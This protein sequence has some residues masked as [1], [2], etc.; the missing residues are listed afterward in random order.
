[1]NELQTIAKENPTVPEVTEKQ[2]IEYL[3]AMGMTKTLPEKD[4]KMFIQIAQ[5]FGLNPFKR[6]I[7][8]IPYKTKDGTKYSILTGYE[9]YLKRAARLGTLDGWKCEAFGTVEDGSL[10]AKVT[11][12]R[13]DWSK[14]FEH[15]A[16][17]VEAVNK[18]GYGKPTSIWAKMPIFMTK[19][20]AI[21]QSF[22]LCFSDEFGGLPYTTDEIDKDGIEDV[23]PSAPMQEAPHINTTQQN[24]IFPEDKAEYDRLKKE[25]ANYS[26]FFTGDNKKAL[27][28]IFARNDIGRMQAALSWAKEQE[29]IINAQVDA[30]AQEAE[31]TEIY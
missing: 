5:A 21:A 3:D 9:V 7:Y 28:A 6:E 27:E 26:D 2:I 16:H 10:Y 4:K 25:L 31:A 8:C 19:K 15:T 20:V 13:K 30:E 18:N 12:Y 1:M 14:P 23:T 22:R 11:I 29:A 17:Y 24:K